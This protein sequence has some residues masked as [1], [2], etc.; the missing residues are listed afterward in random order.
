MSFEQAVVRLEQTN[1]AL[2][3]EVIRFR[4]A[5]MGLSNIYPTITEGRQNTADGRYFS[6]PGSGAYMRLYRRSGS[7]A[8][9]IAE[10]PDRTQVQSL[11]DT[12]GGR[13]V[14]GGGD[15]LAKGA[16]G[17]GGNGY[18]LIDFNAKPLRNEFFQGWGASSTGDIPSTTNYY[19]GIDL[20]RSSGNLLRG[21]RLLFNNREAYLKFWADSDSEIPIVSKFFTNRNVLGSVSQ[22]GGV[23]LGGLFE[24]GRNANG[25]YLK[26]PDGTMFCWMEIAFTY[27]NESWQNFSFPQAFHSRP[28][29]SHNLAGTDPS[30]FMRHKAVTVCNHGGSSDHTI[31]R[32]IF[33]TTGTT[34]TTTDLSDTLLVTA[35]GRWKE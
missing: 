4:D 30:Q 10:F 13:G 33:R 28:W 6:V 29:L 23:P 11:V 26:L 15:L 32:S 34:L 2:Q 27:A 25:R 7:S 35:Q 31:G 9:L 8:S 19:P 20:V 22:E 16:Y 18:S 17:L 24:Y 3:E 21:L 12:L 14:V 5:V 1:A